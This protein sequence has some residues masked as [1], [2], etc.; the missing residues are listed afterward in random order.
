MANSN[1]SKFILL[2]FISI[3][4]LLNLKPIFSAKLCK[5][6]KKISNTD[7][8]TNIL[9]FDHKRYRAGHSA[10]NKQGI[11]LLEFSYDGETGDRL[12]Y[13]LKPNGRYYFS[14]ESPTKEITLASK[15]GIIARYESM[16]AFVSLK[17]D[18]P[19][20]KEYFLSISTYSCFMEIYDLNSE[21]LTYDAI[22]NY[23]YLGVQ[24]FSFKFELFETSYSGNLEYYLVFCHNEGKNSQGDTL[25]VKKISFSNASFNKNDII[26]SKTMNTK[27][28]NDRTVTGFLVD[29]VNDNDFKILVAVYT[30]SGNKYNYNVYKLSDLSEKCTG[31]QLYKDDLT[32]NKRGEDGKGHGVFFKM[33]YLGDRD[34]AMAYFLSNEDNQWPRFQVLTIDKKDNCFVFNSKFYKQIEESNFKTDLILNDF[35]KIT[36]TRLAFI[37]TKGESSLY[38]LLIDLFDYNQKYQMRSYEY[39]ISPHKM[40]KELAG[41]VYNGYFAFSST[42]KN[43][44][45]FSIFMI[46]GYANGTDNTIDISPYLMDTGEYKDTNNLVKDLLKNMTIDNNI[47]GYIP[48]NKIILVSYPEEIIFYLDNENTPI[49]NGT[50]IDS[51]YNLIQKRRKIV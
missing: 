18:T 31:W 41:H 27:K 25:S 47:F 45:I 42:I 6:D 2:I 20:T 12:F 50:L 49:A 34:V 7:C 28:L 48:I 23:N 22:Y 43:P 9:K 46:F 4:F 16:N 11:F 21:S 5:D 35:I 29:D 13:A 17:T 44:N 40:D 30:S 37:T 19:K 15:D 51:N 10:T 39:D 32:T 3:I 26:T 38:I 33:I 24:I 8:F 14:N 1:N 36:D